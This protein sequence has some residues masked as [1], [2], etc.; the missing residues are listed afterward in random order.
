VCSG[1]E[2][3]R[4][5][6]DAVDEVKGERGLGDSGACCVGGVYHVA[7]NVVL[8]AWAYFEVMPMAGGG[9]SASSFRIGTYFA[10]QQHI[11]RY[12]RGCDMNI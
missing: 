5:V 7:C 2:V 10:G 1:W 9:H 12:R 4:A 3:A 6:A 11:R 8:A